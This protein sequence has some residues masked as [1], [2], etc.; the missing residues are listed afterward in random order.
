VQNKGE[1]EEGGKND[2]TKNNKRSFISM[3]EIGENREENI[4]NK[5]VAYRP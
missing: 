4:K 2:E 5:L 3:K 1:V